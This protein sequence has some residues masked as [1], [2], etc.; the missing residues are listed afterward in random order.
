MDHQSRESLYNGVYILE[1]YFMLYAFDLILISYHC[2]CL[3][4]FTKNALT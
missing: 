1:I 3:Q 2:E 4:C